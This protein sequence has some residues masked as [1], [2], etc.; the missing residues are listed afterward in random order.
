MVEEDLDGGHKHCERVCV[1]MEE[2]HFYVHIHYATLVFYL[3]WELGTI[4]RTFMLC[5]CTSETIVV[6]ILSSLFIYELRIPF[7]IEKHSDILLLTYVLKE[8]IIE[9]LFQFS[10]MNESSNTRISGRLSFHS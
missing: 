6:C 10:E 7:K 1:V 8:A 9:R 3:I 5:V 2:L 4:I